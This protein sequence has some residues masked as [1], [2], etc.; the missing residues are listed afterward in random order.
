MQGSRQCCPVCVRIL[1]L[2]VRVSATTRYRYATKRGG[3]S[4]LSR[5]HTTRATCQPTLGQKYYLVC[6]RIKIGPLKCLRVWTIPNTCRLRWQS[7]PKN[8]SAEK[9]LE[10]VACVFTVLKL[11][12]GKL[13][14]FGY[15]RAIH[16]KIPYHISY[17]YFVM[18]VWILMASKWCC[19]IVSSYS[20]THSM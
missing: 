17:T 3:T 10:K 11:P 15:R 1:E 8:E 2:F 12:F 13:P 16:Q 4:H 5:E 19:K 6:Q 18:R 20:S 14:G 9:V 7:L